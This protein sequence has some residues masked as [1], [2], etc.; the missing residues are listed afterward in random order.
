MTTEQD[1]A[2]AHDEAQ[3]EELA[4]LAQDMEDAEAQYADWRTQQGN[5]YPNDPEFPQ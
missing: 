2:D 4:R 1:R 3:S 5:E